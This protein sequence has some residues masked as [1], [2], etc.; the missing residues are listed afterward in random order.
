MSDEN[1]PSEL[2]APTP[3]PTPTDHGSILSGFL[4]AAGWNAA[5][6]ALSV[7]LMAAFVGIVLVM[8]YGLIQFA[9]LLPM[10]GRYRKA[11]KTESAKGVLIVAGISVL[12]S[13]ACWHSFNSTSFR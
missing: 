5:A 3:E 9:W 8:G 13:A 6:L 1:I 2:V 11:G 10:W 12:L 4:V 7:A